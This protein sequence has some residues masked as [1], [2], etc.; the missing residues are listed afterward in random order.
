MNRR[1]LLYLMVLGTVV[2]WGG[3]FPLT[4]VALDSL[5]PSSIAFLRWTVSAVA[6][7]GWLTRGRKWPAAA[8]MMRQNGRTVV[9]VAVTGITLFYLLENTALRYTSAINAGVLTNLIPVFMVLI[10]TLWLRERL[11]PVEWGALVAAFAGAVLVSQGSGHLTFAGRG[12][13]VTG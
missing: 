13:W 3:S 1:L 6:L 12:S 4:K 8:R 9:W 2:L 10:A 5:G 11:V 7:A